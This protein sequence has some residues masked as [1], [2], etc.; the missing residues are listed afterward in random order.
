MATESD[1][2][3]YGATGF[4]GSRVVKTLL[5]VAPQSCR[6]AVGGR[7]K[8]KLL[9]VLRDI[10]AENKAEVVIADVNDEASLIDMAKSTRLVLNCV[11][12]YRLWGDA[13]VSACIKG[14]AHYLD[15]S[16]EPEF[17]EEMEYKYHNRAQEAG[18]IIA[19]AAGF[20]SVPADMGTL[21]TLQQPQAPARITMVDSFLTLATGSAGFR[22]HFP[23]W[24]CAVLGVAAAGELRA[25][26]TKM[27]DEGKSPAPP[28]IPGPKPSRSAGARFS[29][30]VNAWAL[31][32]IGADASIVRRSQAALAAQGMP[33]THYTAMFTVGSRW[34]VFLFGLFGSVFM[35]LARTSWG[36]GLLLR[37]PSLFSYGL[38]SHDGPT[39]EMM[40]QTRFS[41]TFVARG[42][43]SGAPVQASDK[44]DMQIVTRVEGPEPGY[45]ATP[46]F[47]SAAGLTLLEE[48]SALRSS[49]GVH[50][51]A[52]LFNGTSYLDKLQQHG[53]SFSVV[54]DGQV[55]GF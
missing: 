40:A 7:D 4:T 41:M 8:G 31:P 1:V 32:F 24:Q 22:G 50:T 14:K 6:V 3:V 26:R 28:A 20:D 16:G 5:Q 44:P 54:S 18:V 49:P 17:I 19:S 43:K 15:I 13:V 29:K 11:G 46:I 27:K 25:L 53:I 39:E 35:K 30:T 52:T 33:A 47:L 9:A 10:G 12:P 23:T 21:F 55:T 37:Y 42:F 2:V 36:R 38:F 34:S 51:V 45:V 48:E